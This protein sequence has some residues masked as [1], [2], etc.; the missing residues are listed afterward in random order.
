MTRR[1]CSR[2]RQPPRSRCWPT[3]PTSTA[4]PGAISGASD[5]ANGTVVVTGG[6]TGLTY[7]PDPNYCN[8]PPGTT[9]D[10]FTYT[11]TPGG[12]TATVTVTVT[13]V[14][15][16]PVA[17]NDAATVLEDAAATAIPVLA[18]DTDVDGGPGASAAASD[19]ANGTVVVTGG[20]TGLTYQPDPNYCNNPP[21]TTLDTFTYTLNGGSTATV[22]VTV[23]CVNDPPVADDETFD[24]RQ[25]RRRQHHVRRQ[26]PRRRR[27]HRDRPEQDDH[28]RP[29][30]RRHR[31][32]RPRPARRRGRHHHDRRR[33]QRRPSRPTATSPSSPSGGDE[34]HRHHRLRSTTPSATRT[35]AR[36]APPPAPS[37]SASP[38]ASGT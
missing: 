3:T 4:A 34:L 8:N 13:C 29:L 1:R 18:N 14:D 16:P 31:H 6:G 38:A 23:T 25:Q 20:G 11:L 36:P 19:P 33:R 10:T 26:R 32:R 12:S 2:T 17:V 35:S 15:D 37:P 30:D 27:T 9:L 22:A 28:R 21:G 5:P 24:R 7:Q